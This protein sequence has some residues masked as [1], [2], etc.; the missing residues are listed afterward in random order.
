MS[1]SNRRG[2]L[3]WLLAIAAVALGVYLAT[4]APGLAPFTDTP[5]FQFVGKVL[6]VPHNPGYPLYVLVSHLFSYVPIGTLAYRINLLSA[7]FGTCTLLLIYVLLR[8]LG[9]RS[10]VAAATVLACGFGRTF[11][12]YSLIA[13]VYTLNAALVAAALLALVVWRQRA[14]PGY[15]FLAVALV[16]VGLGNHTTIVALVPAIGLY[17]WRVDPAF[18]RRPRTV[19]VAILLLGLGLAQYGLI[20]ARTRNA[21]YVE[22]GARTLSDLVGVMIGRQFH[23]LLPGGD[24]TNSVV[25]QAFAVARAGAREL[26]AVGVLLLPFGV[27]RLWAQAASDA[28]LLGF[29]LLPYLLFALA[30]RAPDIEVFLIPAFLIA[31]AIAGSGLEHLAGSSRKFA[32]FMAVLML[33]AV[34][35]AANLYR[36]HGANDFSDH[37]FESTFFD[38]LFDALPS[39]AT[40]LREDYTIDAMVR[41]KVLGENAGAD[42]NVTAPETRNPRWV[43]ELARRGDPVF[44]FRR[45]ERVLE[46][47]GFNFIPVLLLDAP[48][49]AYVDAVPEGSLVALA[50]PAV[51]T[52][53]VLNDAAD[54]LRVLGLDRRLTALTQ[55]SLAL[56]GVSGRPGGVS[57]ASA[58]DARLSL[59]AGQPVG[60][61]GWIAPASL[62]IVADQTV[63]AI[64]LEGRELLRTRAGVVLTVWPPDERRPFSMS[65]ARTT[66]FRVP[67]RQSY[68]QVFRLAG[69]RQCQTLAPHAWTNVTPLGTSGAISLFLPYRASVALYA[70]SA[71]PLTPRVVEVSEHASARLNA[72][73]FPVDE[74]SE[75]LAGAVTSDGL[76]SASPPGATL[77]LMAHLDSDSPD[78]AGMVLSLGGIPSKLFMRVQADRPRPE[79]FAC[80]SRAESALVRPD[81]FTITLSP[82]EPDRAAALGPGWGHA[83]QDRGGTFRWTSGREAALLVPLHDDGWDVVEIEAS[84]GQELTA[85]LATSSVTKPAVALAVN[86]VALSSHTLEP[87]WFTYEWSLPPRAL[88]PGVNSIVLT[89]PD[90]PDDRGL[91]VGRVS[92]TRSRASWLRSWDDVEPTSR[93]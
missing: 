89:V 49:A 64:R 33:A 75:A 78:A 46:V 83:D 5:K 42:G 84:P 61:S 4:L 65:V 34:L 50:V 8:R 74:D 36:N 72:Q 3:P 66:G 45:T 21:P 1:S 55:S 79:P 38:A 16:A 52:H 82:G 7:L 25:E 41:Y 58:R 12:K 14:S 22:W 63:A 24:A 71:S 51:F 2:D 17:A 19:G 93:E 30:Y 59:P 80:V 39:G 62:E 70:E 60:Q 67:L 86:G 81:P 48:L 57:E 69:T 40:L 6:G 47:Q 87:G 31:W 13:E 29:T 43:D 35:P 18:L 54:V 92:V 28:G 27:R 56:A 26:G 76:S 15:F 23:D 44:A 10:W 37:R 32:G 91:A 20:L 88:R 77:R 68:L 11:W 9:C 85:S 53:A 73:P 90:S